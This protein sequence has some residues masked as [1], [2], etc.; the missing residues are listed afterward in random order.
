[1]TFDF[2]KILVTSI[3]SNKS[4]H[5]L[6]HYNTTKHSKLH[7]GLCGYSAR[8]YFHNSAVSKHI[9]AGPVR[10]YAGLTLGFRDL[11]A[12][13]AAGN[14]TDNHPLLSLLQK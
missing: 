8:L 4:R 6:G 3:L 1:M 7:S 5:L 11:H 2:T 10:T 13:F 9:D 14:E 12:V